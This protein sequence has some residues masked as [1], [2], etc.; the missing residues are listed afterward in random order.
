MLDRGEKKVLIENLDQ[1]EITYGTNPSRNNSSNQ[2]G[3]NKEAI[4]SFIDHNEDH[5]DEIIDKSRSSRYSFLA[6]DHG[7]T[8]FQGGLAIL[9]TCVGAGIV[10]L[11][12]A[13]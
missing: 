5:N 2:K 12:Q 10:G 4:D 9:S 11:P 3:Q 6:G 7:F 13:M 1:E 8:A